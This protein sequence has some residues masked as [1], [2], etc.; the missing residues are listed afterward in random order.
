VNLESVLSLIYCFVSF[1]SCVC[2][3]FDDTSI[4]CLVPPGSLATMKIFSFVT[5]TLMGSVVGATPLEVRSAYKSDDI[6]VQGIHKLNAYVAKNG[7]PNPQ[8][9]TLKNAAVRKEWYELL[10]SPSAVP[11]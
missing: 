5:V 10:F 9:C 11:N 1:G 2:D 6:M 8:K 7:Y 4:N 3:Y